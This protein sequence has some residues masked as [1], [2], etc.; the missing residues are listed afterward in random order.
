LALYG[1]CVAGASQIAELES[2]LHAAGF[3]QVGNTP[4]DVSRAFTRDW[5]PGSVIVSASMQ[6]ASG[7]ATGGLLYLLPRITSAS[8][9]PAF[10]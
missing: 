4:K 6:K 8:R 9:Y 2:M 3:E 7:S 5:A 10:S 1:G